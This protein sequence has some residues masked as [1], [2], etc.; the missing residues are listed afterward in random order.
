MFGW[1]VVLGFFLSIATELAAIVR[2]ERKFRA[3]NRA[4]AGHIH[5]EKRDG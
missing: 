3:C 2:R 4:L 1:M 5:C